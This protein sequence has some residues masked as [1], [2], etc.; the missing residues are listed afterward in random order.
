[1]TSYAPTGDQGVPSPRAGAGGRGGL[2]PSSAPPLRQALTLGPAALV[3]VGVLVSIFLLLM[4]VGF[5]LVLAVLV[6][7]ALIIGGI[8]LRTSS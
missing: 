3:T 5:V 2:V 8:T 7:L 4:Q 1:M 6:G